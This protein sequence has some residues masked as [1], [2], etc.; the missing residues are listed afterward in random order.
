MTKRLCSCCS[1]CLSFFFFFFCDFCVRLCVLFC[2]VVLPCLVVFSLVFFSGQIKTVLILEAMQTKQVK[3]ALLIEFLFCAVLLLCLKKLTK[4]LCSCCS[5]CLSLFF[6]FCVRLGVLLGCLVPPCLALFSLVCVCVCVCVC[7]D[8]IKTV[9]LTLSYIGGNAGQRIWDCVAQWLFV[10]C[11]SVVVFVKIDKMFMFMLFILFVIILFIFV[12]VL[13]C[14]W[15]ALCRLVQF[16]VCVCVFSGKIKTATLT[17]S[18][19]GGNAGQTNWD[20]V[21]QWVLVLCRSVTQMFMFLLFCCVVSFIL[22]VIFFSFLFSSWCAALCCL[23][24]PCLVLFSLV[25]FFSWPKQKP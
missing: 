19:I 22:F 23:V 25:C 7:F 14:C 3:I 4:C 9:T 1:S 12:F 18:Y 6:H 15:V 11:R 20:C 16:G 17:V 2:C 13:V 21:A 10:L 5:S 8:Q 24:L